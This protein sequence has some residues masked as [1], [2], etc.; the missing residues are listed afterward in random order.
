MTGRSACTSGCVPTWSTSGGTG[1]TGEA[2]WC[3]PGR[4]CAEWS[5]S[6]PRSRFPRRHRT[7]RSSILVAF[8]VAIV[9]LVVQG[10]TLPWLIR[11]LK[12]QGSDANWE[13]RKL[14]ELLAELS[15]EGLQVLD[16]PHEAVGDDVQV[17]P[18]VVERVRRDSTLRVDAAWER[19][20]KKADG[21][22]PHRQYRQ[23]RRA[24]V[25]AE[26]EALLRARRDGIYPSRVL[27]RAQAM[28]ELEET[29]LDT[30]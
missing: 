20:R 5:P 1:W 6:P 2:A 25:L 29:R 9:T 8:T 27:S 13:N 30:H 10:G 19:V 11:M 15:T 28:L 24:V 23:L 18:K 12:I 3:C 26:Y 16:R 22:T 21:S 17:D 4:G 14:A 7:G